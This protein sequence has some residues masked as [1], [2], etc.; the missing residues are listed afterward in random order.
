MFKLKEG[1]VW[2]AE[3]EI[4]ELKKLIQF[5]NNDINMIEM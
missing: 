1:K 2:A 5:K 3:H 4:K